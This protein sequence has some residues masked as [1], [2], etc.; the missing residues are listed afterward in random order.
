[1]ADLHILKL[2]SHELLL[3]ANAEDMESAMKWFKP[4]LLD[5]VANPAC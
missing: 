5:E 2:N 4:P 1:M 3:Q